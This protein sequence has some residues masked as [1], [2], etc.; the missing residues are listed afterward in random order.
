MTC[1]KFQVKKSSIQLLSRFSLMLKDRL[2]I[3]LH[4]VLMLKISVLYIHTNIPRPTVP[5]PFLS[6]RRTPLSSAT[7]GQCHLEDEGTNQMRSSPLRRQSPSTR[8]EEACSRNELGNPSHGPW[9]AKQLSDRLAAASYCDRVPARFAP[10]CFS[11]RFC[12]TVRFLVE[13][14]FNVGACWREV[15]ILRRRHLAEEGLNG[16]KSKKMQPGHTVL[17]GAYLPGVLFRGVSGLCSS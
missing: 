12:R 16:Q 2:A 3:N 8:P 14:L 10:A 6:N 11:F 5:K 7:R 9:E 15:V 17:P 13:A 4:T 1:R